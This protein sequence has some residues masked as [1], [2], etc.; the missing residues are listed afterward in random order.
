[1]CNLQV[2][3]KIIIRICQRENNILHNLILLFQIARAVVGVAI[4]V[5]TNSSNS[6]IISVSFL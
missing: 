4:P 2:N 1:M 5:S 3:I 6:G